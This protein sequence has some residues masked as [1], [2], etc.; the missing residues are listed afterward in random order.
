MVS[1]RSE[2]FKGAKEGGRS[3]RKGVF[4]PSKRL[5]SAFCNPPPLLRTLLRTP[6][7][8]EIR[9]PYKVGAF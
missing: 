3:L 2:T 8:T 4:L 1:C 5:L 6:V 7:P 9:N